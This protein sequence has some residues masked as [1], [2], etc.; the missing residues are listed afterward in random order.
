MFE[1]QQDKTQAI[2]TVYTKSPAYTTSGSCYYLILKL[3]HVDTSQH[4]R[5]LVSR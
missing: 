1:S 2:L 3:S 4:K 5:I